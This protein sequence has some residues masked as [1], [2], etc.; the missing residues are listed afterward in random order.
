VTLLGY[1]QRAAPRDFEVLVSNDAKEWRK[2]AERKESAVQFATER[3][4]KTVAR[5]VKVVIHRD[6]GNKNVA[7]TGVGVHRRD[8]NPTAVSDW[9]SYGT[10]NRP[11]YGYSRDDR[12]WSLRWPSTL[13]LDLVKPVPMTL[14]FDG[15]GANELFVYGSNDLQ[16]WER[17]D[18]TRTGEPTAYRYE[19][20][21]SRH[22]YLKVDVP[23]VLTTGAF[24]FRPQAAP[25]KT[26]P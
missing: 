3:F 5:Y 8:G 4:P 12:G 20:P 17:V 14:L 26:A 10:R 18:V 1:S 9:N 16:K 11:A 7:L 21:S 13:Y 6:N 2:V 15:R 23:K 22:R 25:A 19:I 24:R